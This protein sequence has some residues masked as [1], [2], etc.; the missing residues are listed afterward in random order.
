MIAGIDYSM[1]SP[2]ITVGTSPDFKKCK[3]FFYTDKKK[4]CN[5]YPESII[6]MKS[7]PY[8]S[9]EERFNN[10]SEWALSIMKKFNVQECMVEDYAMGAKGKVFHIA[11]NTGLLKH[12]LWANNIIM[13]TVAPTSAKK[14]FAGK[15]NANKEVMHEAFVQ[16][17]GVHVGDLLGAKITDSPCSDIV[18]SYAMLCY[19]FGNK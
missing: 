5:V 10:I 1:T 2:A 6:G 15:G 7:F 14:Y 16:Q 18:D 11:E 13:Y 17:T 8:E 3:T 9:Q 12:K 19:Y 4:F